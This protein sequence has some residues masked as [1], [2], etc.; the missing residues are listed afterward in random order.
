MGLWLGARR[1]ERRTRIGPTLARLTSQANESPART[2]A[3][4]KSSTP[5]VTAPAFRFRA[6]F[7]NIHSPTVD[8]E[9]VEPVDSRFCRS[10]VRHLNE[11]ESPRLP[12]VPVRHDIHAVNTS[13]LRKR[14][15]QLVLG[16]LIIEIPYKNIHET[17]FNLGIC[18]C[19]NEAPNGT[20]ESRHKKSGCQVSARRLAQR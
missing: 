10:R 1:R 9:T 7:V 8:F 14:S 2:P 4:A 20:R 18:L 19:L 12:R 3:T 15:L 11:G 13:V 17:P 5:T 16:G 6:S